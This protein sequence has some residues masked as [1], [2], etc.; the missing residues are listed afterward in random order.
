MNYFNDGIA[1]EM[2]Q[3]VWK[4]DCL[5]LREWILYQSCTYYYFSVY[6]HILSRFEWNCFI[7][8]WSYARV[9]HTYEQSTVESFSAKFKHEMQAIFFYTIK[10]IFIFFIYLNVFITIENNHNCFFFFRTKCLILIELLLIDM[11]AEA[12]NERRVDQY[13]GLTIEG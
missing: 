3:H 13:E 7:S 1:S 11:K 8:F 4:I 5:F 10:S 12:G 9:R 6:P 2:L